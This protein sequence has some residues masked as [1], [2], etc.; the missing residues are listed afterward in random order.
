MTHAKDIKPGMKFDNFG[1]VMTVVSVTDCK[2]EI[3]IQ[4]DKG[5]GNEFLAKTDTINMPRA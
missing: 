3:I 5:Y 4:W 1:D 2:N